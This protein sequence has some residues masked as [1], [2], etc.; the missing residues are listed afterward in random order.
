MYPSGS[1]KSGMKEGEKGSMEHLQV[2]S[3]LG[4]IAIHIK[5]KKDTHADS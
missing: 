2:D 1:R 5:Q 4:K 3:V